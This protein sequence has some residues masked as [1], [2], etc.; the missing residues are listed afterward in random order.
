MISQTLS[1][2][3]G[4]LGLIGIVTFLMAT[5]M[6]MWQYRNARM[7]SFGWRLRNWRLKQL[8][9]VACLFFLAMAASYAILK[10]AWGWLYLVGAFKT[11]SWWLRYTFGRGS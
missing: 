3:L 4:V 11:G 6:V 9:A 8:S 1:I 10:E 2:L 7:Q 5:G